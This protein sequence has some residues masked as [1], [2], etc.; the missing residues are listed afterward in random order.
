MVSRT[1]IN[2]GSQIK[3]SSHKKNSNVL[4]A[5]KDAEGCLDIDSD[6]L[7]VDKDKEG[8]LDIDSNMLLVDK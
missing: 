1:L 4:V 6:V 2:V 3:K 5:D 7:L 8:C